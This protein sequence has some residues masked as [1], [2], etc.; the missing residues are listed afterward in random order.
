MEFKKKTGD[1]KQ[2][3]TREYI[4]TKTWPFFGHEG[5]KVIIFRKFF[6]FD[7]LS[8]NMTDYSTQP[9]CHV[10]YQFKFFY[11]MVNKRD[12]LTISNLYPHNKNISKC[13]YKFTLWIWEYIINGTIVYDHFDMESL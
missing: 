10:E 7:I 9:Y 2:H 6:L 4:C 1:S 3:I 13:C 12:F 11:K 5:S 8:T